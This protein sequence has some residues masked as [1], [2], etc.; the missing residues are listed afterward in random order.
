MVSWVF[1]AWLRPGPGVTGC[2]PNGNP[3]EKQSAPRLE[4]RADPFCTDCGK[5]NLEFDQLHGK[6]LTAGMRWNSRQAFRRSA[7]NDRPLPKINIRNAM[8][9]VKGTGFRLG[10]KTRYRPSSHGEP[11]NDPHSIGRCEVSEG[12][13]FRKPLRAPLPSFRGHLL[14]N[15]F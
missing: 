3:A 5:M 8:K 14:S 12:A 9:I 13:I 10:E 7:R 15:S 11:L 4:P 6:I 2:K 1:S